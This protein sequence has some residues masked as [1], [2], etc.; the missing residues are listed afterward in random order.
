MK[1][2]EKKKRANSNIN[3]KSEAELSGKKETVEQKHESSTSDQGDKEVKNTLI[4]RYK[5]YKDI[6]NTGIQFFVAV[7]TLIVILVATCQN[8]FAAQS[9]KASSDAHAAS[10]AVLKFYETKLEE[11]KI[12]RVQESTTTPEAERLKSPSSTIDSRFRR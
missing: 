1:R 8:K 2:D 9:A 11:L 5:R 12:L 10:K 7:F 4:K 6:I 3:P